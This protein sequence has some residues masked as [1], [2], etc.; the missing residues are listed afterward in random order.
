[1][2]DQQALA[3]RSDLTL[4]VA[5]EVLDILGRPGDDED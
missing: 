4:G 5:R 2:I 3:K 1:M